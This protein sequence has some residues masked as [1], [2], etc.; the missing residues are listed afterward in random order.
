[1][2][3]FLVTGGRSLKGTIQTSGAKNVAM[4]VI[5]AG[6]LTDDKV[7]VRNI[8]L[9]SSVYGT[10]DMVKKLGVNV[11][12]GL[13]HS[14]TIQRNSVNSY[15]IPLELGGLYRTA[16][17]VIGPLLSRFG[18]AVVPNPGGCRIGKRPIDRHIEGLRAL[19]AEIHYKNGFFFA[20]CKKLHGASY[21]FSQNSHTGTETLILAAVLAYGETA[22]SNAATEPEVDDLI[23]FLNS[24][25]AKIKRT[26]ERTIVIHGVGKLH[27]T[28][29]TIMPD[30]NEAV[31]FA[32]AAIAT[33]GD[34]VV[35]GA[36]AS[37]L[38]TFLSELTAIG[39]FWEKISPTSIRF[40]G[41]NRLSHSDIITRPHPGFMT[42]WQA[43][44]A[45]LMT[46]AMGDS[47]L[48]ETVYEN[49]FEYVAELLKMGATITFY[50]PE[51]RDPYVFYNFNWDDRE[52][53]AFHAI[54]I[55]GPTKLHNA[56]LEVTDLRAG[57]T[58]VLAALIAKGESAILGIEH[59][60]RGYESLEKRLEKIGANISR[61]GD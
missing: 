38:K 47:T 42:D 6:L 56:V 34:V 7:V 49:R 2:S 16:T 14:L 17:M 41:G 29:Y 45:L 57:A 24:M 32:I 31:T 1:M 53:N 55:H 12:V 46:Q 37:N 43:P 27:G 9:I 10:I 60:D 15:T 39:A 13:D 48:H 5:L 50:Q 19:G 8:P 25:G 44:W 21:T 36:E 3:K 40:K 18:K 51:I 20:S 58:L 30:R 33:G 26:R 23:A 52:K 54:R 22:L 28:N 61:E 4:K 11:R 59:I 35:E